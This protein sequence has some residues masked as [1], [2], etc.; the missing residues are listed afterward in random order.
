MAGSPL[1]RRQPEANLRQERKPASG[2]SDSAMLRGVDSLYVY[3]AGTAADAAAAVGDALGLRLE[4]RTSSYYGGD[5][6]RAERDV[7]Q[8]IVLENYVEDDDEPFFQSQPVG[9]ICVQV[10]G[11]AEAHQRLRHV[12]GLQRADAA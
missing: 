2:E 7:D 12:R 6:Y 9:A 11:F 10:S 4:L 8:V 3:D 1:P 5:Y